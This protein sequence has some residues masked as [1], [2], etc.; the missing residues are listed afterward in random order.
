MNAAPYRVR[1]A[2]VDDLPQLHALWQA[3]GITEPD[4]DKRLT[5]FQVAES[6]EGKFI[7]AVAMR[8]AEGQGLIL[9][10]AF[11]DFS[12]ADEV[13]PLLWER[14]QAV[15]TNHG[16]VRVWTR[17]AAP[18]W[19]HCGLTPASPETLAKLPAAWQVKGARWFAFQRREEIAGTLPAEREFDLFMQAERERTKSALEQAKFLKTIAT[20]LAIILAVAVIGAAIYLLRKN[21]LLLAP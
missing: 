16:L 1:R 19:S 4:L 8:I 7:G 9:H 6:A 12:L 10:E 11:A 20:A 2:T 18:F 15:A 13:R 21:P 17:E 3:M 14:M 5:E